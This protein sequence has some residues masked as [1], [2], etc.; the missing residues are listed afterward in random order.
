MSAQTDPE[1]NLCKDFGVD[2]FGVGCGGSVGGCWVLVGL[3]LLGGL[4]FLLSLFLPT[5]FSSPAVPV[6]LDSSGYSS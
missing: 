1:T 4:L 5:T 2:V 6:L 3:L